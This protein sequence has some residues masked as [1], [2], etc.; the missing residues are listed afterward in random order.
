MNK[1]DITKKL[2]NKKIRSISIGVIVCLLIISMIKMGASTDS[3]VE[4]PN[5]SSSVAESQQDTDKDKTQ[6]Q[7]NSGESTGK[8]DGK[9]EDNSSSKNDKDSDKLAEGTHDAEGSGKQTSG[10]S[11]SSEPTTKPSESTSESSGASSTP[12]SSKTPETPKTPESPES[13]ESESNPK[14]KDDDEKEEPSSGST[15][16]EKNTITVSMEIECK[17]IS[18]DKSVIT[19]KSILDYVPNDGYIL[20][21]KTIDVAPGTTAFELT[22]LLC[23]SNGVALDFSYTP[24]FGTYYIKGIGYIYEKMAGSQSGWMYLVNGSSP[25]KGCDGYVLKDGD[26]VRWTYVTGM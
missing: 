22:Q 24:A 26:H 1:E 9:A 23:D 3:K 5:V 18:A 10:Q 8:E 25:T 16:I 20:Y 19:D 6:G 7:D 11:S 13:A 17:T 21:S 12:E 2:R 14:P 15:E 4:S